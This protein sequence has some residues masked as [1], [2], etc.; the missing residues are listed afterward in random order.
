MLSRELNMAAKPEV[1]VTSTCA[2]LY[3]DLT[4]SKRL[5]KINMDMFNYLLG[6]GIIITVKSWY[7]AYLKIKMAA[8]KPEVSV[9]RQPFKIFQKF[10][11]LAYGF[12]PRPC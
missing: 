6:P 5:K 2:R 10:Q 12:C 11:R 8:S 7:L 9:S 4:L 3:S 1:G